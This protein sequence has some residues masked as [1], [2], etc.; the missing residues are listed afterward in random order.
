MIFFRLYQILFY[1]IQPLIWLRL[2]Y[3]SQKNPA[4]RERWL[5]RYGF[6]RG[7]VGKYGIV[8]HSVSVGETLAAVPLVRALR[9]HYPDLAITITTM[10]PTGSE[11]VRS[12]FGDDVYHVYLPYDLAGATK[13]FLD[14]AE[15]KLMII[16]ETEL[17]PNLIYQLSKKQIPLV[18]A[19]A[20]LSERSAKGYMKIRPLMKRLL[21]RITL[22]AAQHET[23]GERFIELGLRRAQLSVTGSLKFDISVTPDLAARA[24][25]LRRQWAH[26]RPVWI[27][28]S[29]HSGE[30]EILL[31]AHKTLLK[32]FPNL[33][34]ILVPRH[35]E[36]FYSVQ[37]LTESFGFNTLM[38]SSGNIP[39]ETDEVIVGDTM[40][41]LM[42]LYGI[43]DIAFVGGS[44]VETG[45]HNPL[46]AAAHALPV[47]M[48][49]HTFNFQAI[50]EKLSNA[51]A[52][53]TVH[54]QEE[55]VQK[56]TNLLTDE[57]FRRY[58]GHNA[59][60]VLEKNHG[61]LDKLLEQLEPYLPQRRH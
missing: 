22:I 49:P 4:Y 50:C 18:I 48:G 35:P 14:E 5:E 7:K 54:N 53:M 3:R 16:M 31:E 19:N 44:L 47:I 8:L 36:R 60:D 33:L 40:G 38:R 28:A 45:G 42:L 34:L 13:R 51:Q 39:Q 29:T 15:P 10:T 43:A 58:Y 41:E 52:L 25:T 12:A 24:V 1:L 21:R 46:E 59:V 56:V 37:K 23:D 57:D 2:L 55:L 61:A 11:R 6:C 26:N 32:T 20:R 30:D 9:T 17:W 27:A